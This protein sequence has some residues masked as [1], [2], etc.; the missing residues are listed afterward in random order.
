M[1]CID[2]GDHMKSDQQ[3]QWDRLCEEREDTRLRW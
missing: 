2:F 3:W 1:D